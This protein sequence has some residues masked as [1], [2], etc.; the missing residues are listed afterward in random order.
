MNA[1]ITP[2]SHSQWVPKLLLSNL[3]PVPFRSSAQSFRQCSYPAATSLSLE[4]E[5]VTTF[6]LS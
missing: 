1:Q 3:T 5:N 2:R 6:S 4:E